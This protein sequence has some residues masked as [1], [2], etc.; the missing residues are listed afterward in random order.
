MMMENDQLRLRTYKS[1]F[2]D[3]DD[4]RKG[5]DMAE[6]GRHQEALE[7]IRKFINSANPEQRAEALNDTGAILHCLGRSEDAISY[8]LR[9]RKQNSESAEILWN[10]S[11]I[12]LATGRPGEAAYL[13]DDMKK[14]EILNVDILNRTANEFLNQNNKAGAVEMLLQS[15][16]ICPE[17]EILM[18]MLIHDA[19]KNT[20]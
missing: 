7:Y 5:L 8:F 3:S 12:Y 1:A 11:E 19:L 6:A 17:Q 2:R 15:L 18:P 4:Y 14:M 9:A 20:R 16:Y 13:F 10:L